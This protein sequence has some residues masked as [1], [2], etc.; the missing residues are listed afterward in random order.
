MAS[1][2][3]T[4]PPPPDD[5]CILIPVWVDYRWIAPI[6]MDLLER[7]WPN[8]P[9]IFLVGL[10]SE[11]AG[12]FPHF[13]ISDVSRQRNWC[14]MTRDGVRQ[15]M[16]AGFRRAYVL[17]EEHVALR[18]CHERHLHETLPAMMDDL[19]AAYIALMGWDNRRHPTK[20]PT[21]G[22]EHYRMRHL[23]NDGSL[24]FCL[25]PALWRLDV[26][27]RC[28]EIS[29][30]DESKNGSAWHFERTCVKS[31]ADLPEEWKRGCYQIAAAEMS[32]RPLSASARIGSAIEQW[33][34]ARLMAIVPHIPKKAWADAYLKRVGFA[35]VLCDGPYP[36]VFT[37]ILD[38]GK[39]NPNLVEE[40]QKSDWGIEIL[41]RIARDSG[42][43][44]AANIPSLRPAAH[45]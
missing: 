20:N 15:A 40:L 1:V 10:T 25:H 29:L 35:N 7:H 42:G 44:H 39:L 26:L 30:R 13:P 16:D 4:A 43:K 3:N 28:C 41:E 12:D 9:P 21:L 23:R 38:L 11:Q 45:A 31:T 37:G 32:M 18:S 8:H 5:L 6:A 36:M 22:P 14:W 17:L 34:F 2:Q 27:A 24:R 19:D 33:I